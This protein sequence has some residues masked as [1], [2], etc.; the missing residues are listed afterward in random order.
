M[1]SFKDYLKKALDKEKQ[2]LN[3]KTEKVKREVYESSFSGYMKKYKSLINEEDT[4]ES[5][6]SET[7][8][9][10]EDDTEETDV[11]ETE[12][13]DSEDDYE[14]DEEDEEASSDVPIATKDETVNIENRQKAIDEF[15][16]GPEKIDETNDDFWN[17][18]KTKFM[19]KTVDLAKQKLCG[20]C[21]AFNI[22]T[23]MIKNLDKGIDKEIDENDVWD[24]DKEN[25]GF[26][27][28]LDFKC[29]AKRTCNSWVEGGPL[30]D[31]TSTTAI[32]VSTSASTETSAETTEETPAE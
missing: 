28:F 6:T 21:A 29:H 8:K 22:K 30:K 11:E 31:K 23:E 16:Y 2:E 27:E 3:K 14:K 15:S 18:K 9:Y 17:E 24:A 5:E 1:N 25:R 19:V 13:T 4:E 10:L 7:D 12:E 20:N 32:A 26:C